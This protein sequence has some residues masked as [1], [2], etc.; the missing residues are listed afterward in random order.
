MNKIKS[1]FILVVLLFV[2]SVIIT[3]VIFRIRFKK[4]VKLLFSTV[5][6]GQNKVFT[7]DQIRNLPEP[8]QRYFRYALKENQPDIACVR[9]KHDGTFRPDPKKGW[10][11]IRGEQYF[12]VHDP[13]FI[14]K[15]GISIMTA[16]DMYL[17]NKGRLVITLLSLYNIVDAQGPAYDQA[18][19]LRWLIE[20]I[21][22]PTALLPDEN[23]QWT[24][25]D[26]H[27]AGLT[28]KY[29]SLS[30]FCKVFI[31]TQGEITRIET[32][33]YM[34]DTR[35]E[36]WIGKCSEYKE[37]NGVRI[38]VKIEAAWLLDTGEYPYARFN[39]QEIEYNIPAMY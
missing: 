18:E 4:E 33:R 1:F 25:I 27:S 13:G 32:K 15:A 14:W 29:H 20:H 35:M 36:T 9:L 31:N 30:L 21:W 37:R 19:L 7:Y 28:F 12:N 5:K 17:N 3:D 2:F 22:F 26:R 11:K 24:A 10:M 6:M 34:S 16:R 23:L 38:P 8:V 39:I